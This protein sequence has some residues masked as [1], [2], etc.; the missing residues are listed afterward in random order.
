VP[1]CPSRGCAGDR[2]E[3]P[4]V[5]GHGRTRLAYPSSVA[6]TARVR[7]GM[8][9]GRSAAASMSRIILHRVADAQPARPWRGCAGRYFR[10]PGCP[11]WVANALRAARSP[12][13]RSGARRPWSVAAPPACGWG[14]ARR[15]RRPRPGP[16]SGRSL[17][18]SDTALWRSGTLVRNICDSRLKEAL[19]V[20][21]PGRLELRLPLESRTSPHA[22]ALTGGGPSAVRVERFTD[23]E[24]P[25]STR[26]ALEERLAKL[27]AAL[28][29]GPNR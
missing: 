19:G 11:R 29:G 21:A 20:R 22:M 12:P 24:P 6:A 9:A 28:Q 15:G 23:T 7:R 5:R 27:E 17:R 14:C 8:R 18:R 26:R 3:M 10:V 4:E 2:F 13:A 1:A 25:G 16:A